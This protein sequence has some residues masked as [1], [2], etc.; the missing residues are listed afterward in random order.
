GTAA[1]TR[2]VAKVEPLDIKEVRTRPAGVE[3]VLSDGRILFASAR[4]AKRIGAAAEG[5]IDDTGKRERQAIEQR[6]RETGEIDADEDDEAIAEIEQQM[7][8]AKTGKR[9]A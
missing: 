9:G 4:D 1:M 6:R 5:E 2:G 8:D 7:K 3:I